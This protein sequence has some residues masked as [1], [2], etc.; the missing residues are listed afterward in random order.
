MGDLYFALIARFNHLTLRLS[1]KHA[2]DVFCLFVSK[3]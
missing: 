3:F 1:K 2:Q